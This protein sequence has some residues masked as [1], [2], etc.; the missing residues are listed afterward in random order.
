MAWWDDGWDWM[1]WDWMA[2]DNIMLGF[3]NWISY[4][5]QSNHITYI[6]LSN[7]IPSHPIASHP[8]INCFLPFHL[9]IR[10]PYNPMLYHL[11][12]LPPIQSNHLIPF[13][14]LF[15]GF[16]YLCVNRFSLCVYMFC[17]CIYRFWVCVCLQV[18]W[19][20]PGFMF[21]WK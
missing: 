20:F 11:I 12:P 14:S 3:D 1:Q 10:T 5:I 16:L 19:V 6:I 18:Y 21:L 13:F 7:Y 4:G 2:C 17:L 15:T 8:I 9:N